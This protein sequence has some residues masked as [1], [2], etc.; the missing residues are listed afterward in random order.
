MSETVELDT[1]RFVSNVC[2]FCGK[3]RLLY[4]NTMSGVQYVSRFYLVSK[5]TIDIQREKSS[6]MKSNS[7][8]RG[9]TLIELLIVV[10]IVAILSA[11][12]LPQYQRT[13]NKAHFIQL[14]IAGD[15]MYKAQQAYFLAN[16]EYADNKNALDINIQAPKNGYVFVTKNYIDVTSFSGNLSYVILLS[17]NIRVC[18]VIKKETQTQPS[19]VS[20]Y[21]CKNLTGA[22]TPNKQPTYWEYR[23]PRL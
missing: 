3:L 18:R 7:R 13:V 12:A 20:V 4:M 10:L 9:F 8:K 17:S 19:A 14:M 1:K 6:N 21:V 15:A 22:D 2:H 5:A 23:F 11:I 16:G